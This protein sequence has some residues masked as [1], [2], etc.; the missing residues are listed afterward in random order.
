[1]LTLFTLYCIMLKTNC[2]CALINNAHLSGAIDSHTYCIFYQHQGQGQGCLG[3]HE[4][5]F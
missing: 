5:K 2:K 4:R 1:M 3:L